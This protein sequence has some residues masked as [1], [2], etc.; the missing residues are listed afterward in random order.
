MA[1]QRTIVTVK[2]GVVAKAAPLANRGGLFACGQ[3][4]VRQQQAFFRDILLGC[5]MQLLLKQ[6]EQI[7][8]ADKQMLRHLADGRDGTQIFIDILERLGNNGR[9]RGR[10][11]GHGTDG[12]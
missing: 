6:T 10:A 2:R 1:E 4:L 8:F 3:H 12:G 11:G 5:L 9:G 7:A